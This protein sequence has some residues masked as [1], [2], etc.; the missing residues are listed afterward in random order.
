MFCLNIHQ[1]SHFF[2]VCCSRCYQKCSLLCFRLAC[3]ESE[4]W[5][6]RQVC[7]REVWSRHIC[8]TRRSAGAAG[9]PA[10][11]GSLNWGRELLTVSW[12][13]GNFW[14]LN[15]AQNMMI[16]WKTE[17]SMETFKVLIDY[18][19]TVTLIMK[20]WCSLIRNFQFNWKDRHLMLCY[21]LETP[22]S[23]LTQFGHSFFAFIW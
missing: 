2:V 6:A 9:G 18:C 8:T 21:H 3:L 1:T 22:F 10:L 15:I 5:V 14:I 20:F 11:S 19:L 4:A 23:A 13:R 7:T 16:L 12:E 17:I